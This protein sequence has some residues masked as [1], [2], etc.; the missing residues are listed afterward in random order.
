VTLSQPLGLINDLID[1][2]LYESLMDFSDGKG[3][4]CLQPF[5]IAKLIKNCTNLTSHA[6]GFAYRSLFPG[7][8][9]QFHL[10]ENDT[11]ALA[12]MYQLFLRETASWVV[13]VSQ[14]VRSKCS[15]NVLLPHCRPLRSDS[16]E[17]NIGSNERARKSA[18]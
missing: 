13:L 16:N 2:T 6:C 18:D 15:C 11:L 3:T 4:P 1:T 8:Q 5:N 14:P 10:P 12:R 9:L 7:Q 17:K